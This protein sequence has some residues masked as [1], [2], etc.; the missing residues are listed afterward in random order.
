MTLAPKTSIQDCR[1]VLAAL[2][3][4]LAQ[5]PFCE[6]SSAH[7]LAGELRGWGCLMRRPHEAEVEAALEALTVEGEVLS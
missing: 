4:F 1:E 3:E 2:R 6:F 5:H 7:E